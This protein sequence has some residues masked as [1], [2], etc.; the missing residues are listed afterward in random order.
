MLHC[1]LRPKKCLTS[2]N[3]VF[4]IYS[5]LNNKVKIN[6]ITAVAIVAAVIFID[7]SI[8]FYVKTNFALHEAH[9]IT[10]WMYLYF[11]ENSGMAF[12]VKIA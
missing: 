7:Q 4:E 5:V 11:V 2:K 6:A 3:T 1:L 10:S 9:E 12:G 8:K